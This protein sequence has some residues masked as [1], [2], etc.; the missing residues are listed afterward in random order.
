MA[1][2]DK[3][4]V[5]SKSVEPPKFF[6]RRSTVLRMGFGVG[7]HWSCVAVEGCGLV[8]SAMWQMTV[9][10]PP[11]LLLTFFVA[12]TDNAVPSRTLVML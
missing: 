7:L 3:V 9:M 2:Y 8:G 4:W 12:L 6:H 5:V 1:L 11:L 10:C